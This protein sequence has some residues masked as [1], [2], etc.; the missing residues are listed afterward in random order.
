MAATSQIAACLGGLVATVV[1]DA[2]AR[3]QATGMRAWRSAAGLWLLACQAA[4]LF[5]A[6]LALCG[7]LIV[8]SALTLAVLVLLVIASNAKHAMLGEPL[9]FSDLAL[10]GSIFRHPQFYL[11]AVPAWQRTVAAVATTAL[12]ATIAWLFVPDLAA[13]GAGLAIMVIALGLLAV[14]LR[15]PPFR[16]LAR[17]PSNEADVRALGLTPTLML[18][19]LRWRQSRDP[20]PCPSVVRHQARDEAE[21]LPELLPELLVVIQC[22][23]FADPVELFGDTALDLPSLAAARENAWQY[24]ELHVSGFGAYT[25]RT[26]YAVLFGREEEELGFRRYDPFLTALGEASYA[27]PARLGPEWRSLFI[28]PHDM[29]FYGRDAIMPAAGFRQLVGEDRFVPPGPGEGRYVTDAAMAYQIL[30][31][32]EAARGPTLLYAVT[33]EN[34]GPWAPD[35]ATGA[36]NL[37]DSYMQLVRNSDAML[38]RLIGGL[39][40]LRRPAMLVFFGD[41]RPS[42][43][44]ATDPAGPRHTP[45]VLVRLDAEGRFVRGDN[46]RVDLTP[47]GLHHAMLDIVL[48]KPA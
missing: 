9:V 42:I 19:W 36:S 31:L 26:E 41:H 40:A 13:H 4:A 30:E 1:V 15:M 18:Y 48:G 10:I 27:L 16:G 43:P 33:I 5:G 24:G 8:S 32:A 29:R 20:A 14:S 21:L 25:M 11:S 37:V 38:E 47:A 2:L 34:H 45:Y 23:S 17:T 46:R 3:P 44:G 35:A 6:F 7:S 22:E 12:L 39:A 28:H